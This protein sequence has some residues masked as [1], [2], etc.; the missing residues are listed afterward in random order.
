MALGVGCRPSPPASW[1]Q[2]VFGVSPAAR[3]TA[4]VPRASTRTRSAR[5]YSD[6]IRTGNFGGGGMIYAHR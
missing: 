1:R 4:T 6:E 3:A 5:T 2:T